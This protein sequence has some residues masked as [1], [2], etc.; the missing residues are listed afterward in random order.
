MD[1]NAA[2]GGY[3]TP[4]CYVNFLYAALVFV[5]ALAAFLVQVNILLFRKKWDIKRY[6]REKTKLQGLTT[7]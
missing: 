2:L 6:L 3:N 7:I 1:N 5:G 4:L